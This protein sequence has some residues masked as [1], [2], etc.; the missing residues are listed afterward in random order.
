MPGIDNLLVV[1]TMAEQ[2]RILVIE[3]EEQLNRNVVNSLQKDGYIVRGVTSG[4]EAIRLLWSEEYDVAI[5]SQHMPDTDGFEL[6]RWMRN[7]CPNTRMVMLGAPNNAAMRSQALEL[8]AASYLEKPLDLHA[9]KEELRRLLHA[10]GFSASLDSFDLLDV[11]Q[12]MTLSRK[13]IAL[14]VN[15]GLEEQGILRFQNGELIWAEYGILRGE[16]AFYALA[17]HKNGTIAHHTWSENITSNVT[18]PLSRLI[19]Q[20]LQ[21]RSKYADAIQASSELEAIRPVHSLALPPLPSTLPPAALPDLEDDDR[22]FQFVAENVLLERSPT[23]M[24]LGR[25]NAVHEVERRTESGSISQEWW[26]QSGHVPS[27]M[28]QSGSMRAITDA[29]KGAQTPPAVGQKAEGTPQ[30]MLPS[31]LTEQPTNQD[32]P[33]LRDQTGQMPALPTNWSPPIPAQPQQAHVT[34][35][36]APPPG[37]PASTAL[38]HPAHTTNSQGLP[39]L[40]PVSGAVW[41][42]LSS[43]AGLRKIKPE[44]ALY[45]GRQPAIK[46]GANA[47]R[48]A[49]PAE[50]QGPEQAAFQNGHSGAFPTVKPETL[51]S[52]AALKRGEASASHKEVSGL[53]AKAMGEQK[54]TKPIAN[55][56]NET[57]MPKVITPLGQS[58]K[59]NYPALAAALQTLGYSLSGFIASAVV[60]L[61]GTLI[62][63]VTEDDLDISPLCAHVSQ[64][65]RSALEVM[66]QGHW[67]P[68]EYTVLSSHTRNIVLRLI[69]NNSH[70]FQVLITTRET[71][72]AESLD[73]LANVEAAIAAALR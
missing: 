67:E 53:P 69:S 38:P 45:T 58:A 43:E 12:I 13:S 19:F 2:W 30:K 1:A 56:A 29:A 63:Q 59:Y 37:G 52:L 34:N 31:W 6:L 11:I 47:A 15:T 25:L 40:P 21:Y 5:C 61:D 39:N 41:P 23:G 10:T 72:L 49:T 65:V 68:Y 18:Q 60:K 16:E 48:S 46:P 55:P 54:W 32:L 70:V 64:A 8:G 66:Q 50:W 14:I 9:L 27:D 3:S 20:A 73:A 42:D 7:Y 71:K 62:A 33:V 4:A 57:S 35:A 17:A 36:G 28:Q 24:E 26:E 51:H 44:E 22:P